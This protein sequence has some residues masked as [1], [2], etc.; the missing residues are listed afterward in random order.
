MLPQLNAPDLRISVEP[1]NQYAFSQFGTVIENPEHNP[2]SSVIKHNAV[3][4]NQ[5]SALK[6]VDVSHLTN[7]YHSAPSRKPA[8]A[9]VNMF[10]CS[11]RELKPLSQTGD[12][13][14]EDVVRAGQK[15]FPVNI[16]E[17]HPFTPQT[18][19]PTGLSRHEDS[20]AYLVIVAP[21]RP[22][23][24]GNWGD[25]PPPYPEQAPRRRRS[26]TDIFS[27]ARPSPFTEINDS[28]ASKSTS[29]SGPVE[30]KGLGEP[31]LTQMKAFVANGSQSVTYGPGTWH[32]PMV[33]LG[34]TSV[35]FVVVQ[36]ANG[37]A[38]EDCQEM[39]IKH[40]LNSEGLNVVIDDDLLGPNVKIRAKI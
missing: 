20:T 28:T 10:V 27:T 25:R 31:D 12:S 35:D 14:I 32:A 24:S 3:K 36:Y 16:L 17:R 2:S 19:I 26:I 13:G 29:S 15:A 4:A 23:S 18:F 22:T 34:A 11:P 9:V 5:G 8:K 1:L 30:P 6:Y 37:V 21:T 7:Y 38:L 39:E 33:V 40:D